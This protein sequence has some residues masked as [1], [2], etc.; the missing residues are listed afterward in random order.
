MMATNPFDFL[1]STA[2]ILAAGLGTRL[3]PLTLAKPKPLFEVGGRTMLDQ[4]IDHLKEAGIKRIVVNAHYLADQIA[5]QIA[6]RR[7]V[8]TVLSY[9][10]DI[11]DN[12][13][14]VKNARSYFSDKPFFVLNADLPWTEKSEPALS[15]MA[16]VWDGAKMDVLLLLY[17]TDKAKGFA[18]RKDGGQG[19]FMMEPDGHVWRKNAPRDRSFVYISAMLV[20][21]NL[22]DEINE[23]V[24]SNNKIFDL[25]ESRRRLFG[26][27]HQG[28]CYQISSPEDLAEANRLLE[29]GQ[30]WG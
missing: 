16:Q 22:Y 20:K 27:V 7:D 15:R 12:G 29:T 14:G 24:F 10:E 8:E 25:A 28:A 26:L 11:L 2:M 30:G 3:R 23:R 19:D 6:A 4:A 9:E 5:A 21:P 13:G 18:P 17:P 1:S